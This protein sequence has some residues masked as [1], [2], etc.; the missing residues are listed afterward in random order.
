MRTIQTKIEQVSHRGRVRILL[1]WFTNWSGHELLAG[2]VYRMNINEDKGLIMG[3]EHSGSQLSQA[4][5][6][7]LL[8]EEIERLRLTIDLTGLD[9]DINNP[10]DLEVLQGMR[11]V[12][13]MEQ[14]YRQSGGL[15]E[16]IENPGLVQISLNRDSFTGQDGKRY[17]SAGKTEHYDRL[18]EGRDTDSYDGIQ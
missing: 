8:Y 6:I 18:H 2:R 12:R 5:E 16:D 3:V 1:G 13:A 10:H 14:E 11:E 4:N 7:S 9:P 15:G 17:I